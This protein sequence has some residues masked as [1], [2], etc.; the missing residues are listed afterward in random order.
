M[1]HM[2]LRLI[3]LVLGFLLSPAL[4]PE[5]GHAHAET[6]AAPQTQLEALSA[7]NRGLREENARLRLDAPDPTTRRQ[8]IAILAG[9]TGA[10]ALCSMVVF[11]LLARSVRRVLIAHGQTA[12]SEGW[13]AYLNMP[14]G[15]PDGSVRALVSLFVIIFGL[16]V[17]VLQKQIGISNVEAIS[18]F[19]GIVITFYFTARS[20][21]EAQ[22]VADAAQAAASTTQEVV[23]A[24]VARS[25]EVAS[26]AAASTSAAIDR[27]ALEVRAQLQAAPAPPSAPPSAEGPTPAQSSLRDL[28]DRLDAVRQIARAA[29]SL[30]V[31]SEII[32]GADQAVRTAEGLLGTVEPLLSGR[33]DAGALAGVLQ[34]VTTALDPL[35]NAGLPGSLADVMATLKGTFAAAAPILAGIPGGP[36]GIV[37]GI[38]MAGVK[39][40]QNKRQFD[41]LKAALLRKPFD[42]IL[43]PSLVDGVAATAALE[44]SPQMRAVLGDAGPAAATE[45]MRLVTRPTDSGQPAPLADLAAQLLAAGLNVDGQTLPIAGRVASAAEIVRALEEYRSSLVFNAARSQLDGGVELPASAGRPAA[46]LDLRRLVDATQSLGHDPV[47]A[48][49]IEKLVFLAEALAKLPT[50][51]AGAA[52]LVAKALEAAEALLPKRT[53]RREET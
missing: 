41:A 22:K 11:V 38:V 13:K 2:S 8:T 15:V 20:G 19:I 52:G 51:T 12:G 40:A 9:L 10:F 31:G 39:L 7:E 27:A 28:R 25:N 23:R 37:G 48:S 44:I 33:P 3:A 14:L 34:Q 35:E 50:G 26:N 16:V 36:I 49:Q 18:G 4:V 21:N 24:A 5:Y 17:L 29:A 47:M 45:L 46:T 42:P 30:G 43:L 6:A 1:N 53:D 32:A